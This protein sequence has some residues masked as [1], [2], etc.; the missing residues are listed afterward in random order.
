VTLR[1]D[2][3]R[4]IVNQDGAVIL[5]TKAGRISTLNSSGAYVWQA[6]GRGEEFE[7]IAKGLA[8]QAGEPIEAVKEDV[9]RFLDALKKQGLLLD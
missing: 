3:F 4:T 7:I 8:E 1:H 6:M 5:D 2:H 9:L